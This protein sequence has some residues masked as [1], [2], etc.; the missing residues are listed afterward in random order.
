MTRVQL[1]CPATTGA[2]L[3]SLELPEGST[4]APLRLGRHRGTRGADALQQDRGRLVVGVLGDQLAAEGL[5]EQGRVRR[6]TWAR[7]AG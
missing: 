3:S 1:R 7:A 6:S 4:A 5:G 2:T